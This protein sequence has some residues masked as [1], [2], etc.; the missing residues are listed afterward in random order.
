MRIIDRLVPAPSLVAVAAICGAAVALLT[1]S[2][3][4]AAPAHTS[5][6]LPAEQGVAALEQAVRLSPVL[7]GERVTGFALDGVREGSVWHRMGLE[8][9]D[10]VQDLYEFSGVR[11]EDQLEH[12]ELV[13]NFVRD[14]VPLRVEYAMP[15]TEPEPLE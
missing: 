3:A 5:H 8:N 6:V 10:R 2:V 11:S 14:G 4:P 13:V 9:G 1:G 7:E 12:H 15:P